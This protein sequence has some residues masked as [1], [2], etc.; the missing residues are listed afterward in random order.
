VFKNGE[1]H[2]IR[3]RALLVFPVPPWL[4]CFIF[5]VERAIN[6][7]MFQFCQPA[8]YDKLHRERKDAQ[9]FAFIMGFLMTAAS[10]AICYRVINKPVSQSSAE[11]L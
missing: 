3:F 6:K 4:L 7:K 10:T 2:N 5:V 8:L 11:A 9:Y 1:P